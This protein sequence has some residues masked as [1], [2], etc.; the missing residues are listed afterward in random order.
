MDTIQTDNFVIYHQPSP[1]HN[2]GHHVARHDCHK[3]YDICRVV[4]KDFEG[5]WKFVCWEMIPEC[6]HYDTYIE[7]CPWCGFELEPQ[8]ERELSDYLNKEAASET[9]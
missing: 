1:G 5:E 4:E 9:A 7:H 6:G 8:Y 3:R 2:I